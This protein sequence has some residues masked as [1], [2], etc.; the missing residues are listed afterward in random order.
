MVD[1]GEGGE[2]AEQQLQR[3][4]LDVSFLNNS[5]D[6][7]S[8]APPPQWWFLYQ[9][10]A[11]VRGGKVCIPSQF[12]RA[13]VP[14]PSPKVRCL[15]LCADHTDILHLGFFICMISHGLRV[16]HSECRNRTI[17]AA[18]LK[19]LTHGYGVTSDT[20]DGDNDAVQKERFPGS[21]SSLISFVSLD[22]FR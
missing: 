11:A 22:G 13:T 15:A 4:A 1:A 21:T 18:L 8:S 2:E 6:D 19:L 12:G 10:I 16:Q 3:L 14:Y 17:D 20:R 5:I 9:Y 7:P